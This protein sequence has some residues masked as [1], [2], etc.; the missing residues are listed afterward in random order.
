MSRLR[1]GMHRSEND[2]G[3]SKSVTFTR[4]GESSATS[5]LTSAAVTSMEVTPPPHSLKRKASST[6]S[7]LLR[8][9]SRGWNSDDDDEEEAEEAETPRS[10]STR[11]QKVL[12]IIGLSSSSG[13]TSNG[14]D[15]PRSNGDDRPQ[16]APAEAGLPRAARETRPLGAADTAASSDLP[17]SYLG[18]QGFAP[19]G[20]PEARDENLDEMLKRLSG[21][22]KAKST[23]V[24]LD[25]RAVAHANRLR[26]EVQLEVNANRISVGDLERALKDPRVATDKGVPKELV[27]DLLR[28]LRLPRQED[29]VATK[30][31]TTSAGS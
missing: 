20:A 25:R 22:V 18:V 30:A 15:P 23:P 11:L 1:R 14:N 12:R 9:L 27:D 24:E 6:L 4:A 26:R 31:G 8:R 17:E 7:S 21:S 16:L 10:F 2:E 28:S 13:L 5:S 29:Y 3:S 19:G